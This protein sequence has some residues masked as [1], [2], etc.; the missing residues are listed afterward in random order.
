MTAAPAIDNWDPKGDDPRANVDDGR[1]YPDEA[2]I[3]D[4]DATFRDK[5]AAWIARAERLQEQGHRGAAQRAYD[6]S[7]RCA[8]LARP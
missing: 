7:L 5:A 3:R 1:A 2:A 8:G 6:R 4:R